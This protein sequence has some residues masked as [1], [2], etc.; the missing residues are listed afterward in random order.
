[1]GLRYPWPAVADH[2]AEAL[3]ALDLRGAVPQ[4]IPLLDA[5]ELSE[6]Y[7]V[8]QGKTR[9]AV[10]PEVVRVNHLRNCLLCHSYSASPTDPV[11]GLAP[12]AEHLVPLPASGARPPGKW[13]GGGSRGSVLTSTF[14]RADITFL[15]QDFSVL[16]PVPNHG[17]LWPEEQRY[18]YLIR[19][20]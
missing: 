6:P 7:P 12:N 8:D 10:V 3:V 9:R 11:R 13:G 4:L 2:A 18:D 20:R 15:R 1:A 14:V 16:Q 5:R 17:R 19:L